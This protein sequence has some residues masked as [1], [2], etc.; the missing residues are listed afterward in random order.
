MSCSD[1]SE[2]DPDPPGTKGGVSGGRHW[3]GHAGARPIRWVAPVGHPLQDPRVV[4]GSLWAGALAPVAWV[5]RRGSARRCPPGLPA[6]T[7]AQQRAL[8]R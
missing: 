8:R 1:N 6:A 5:G 4:A 7:R 2:N 3:M